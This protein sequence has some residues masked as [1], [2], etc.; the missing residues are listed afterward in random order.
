LVRLRIIPDHAPKA[1]LI[2][3][4]SLEHS[5]QPMPEIEEDDSDAN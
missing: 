5:E 1:V 2:F 4:R 3:S